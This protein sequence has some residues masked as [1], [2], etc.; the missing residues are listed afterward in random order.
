MTNLEKAIIDR[1]HQFPPGK[2]EKVLK[3]VEGL[4]K[5]Q[6]AEPI[7]QTLWEMVRHIIQ[8]IP[9]EE[10]KQIPSDSSINIDHYLYGHDK[11]TA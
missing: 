9:D 3:Y 1:I 11:K 6:S 5:E 7:R 8:E 4:D 2:Q 10:W